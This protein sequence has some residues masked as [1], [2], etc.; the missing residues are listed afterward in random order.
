MVWYPE[1][2][3]GSGVTIILGLYFVYDGLTPFLRRYKP[4]FHDDQTHWISYLLRFLN[5]RHAHCHGNTA[6]YGALI[7]IHIAQIG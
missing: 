7:A 1:P 2:W 3:L 6:L 4:I 5:G